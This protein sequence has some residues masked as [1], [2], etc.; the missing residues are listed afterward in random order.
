MNKYF[1]FIKFLKE[2]EK[3]IEEEYGE[4]KEDNVKGQDDQDEWPFDQYERY[5]LKPFSRDHL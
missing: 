1:E 3:R 4:G 5:G 2:E